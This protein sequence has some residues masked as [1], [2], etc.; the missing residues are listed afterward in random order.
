M[1]IMI[2][3][4]HSVSIKW[5]KLV[6]PLSI[7]A[8]PL[9]RVWPSVLLAS[10]ACLLPGYIYTHTHTHTGIATSGSWWL[11]THECSVIRTEWKGIQ[12]I[13]MHFE[14]V[15]TAHTPA[16]ERIAHR[17]FSLASRKG[18]PRKKRETV[19]FVF[20]SRI[21]YW[22]RRRQHLLLFN[23]RMVLP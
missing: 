19:G 7:H 6:G 12:S 4:I 14:S 18:E 5:M 20:I 21:K 15:V 16:D 1:I 13:R 3:E 10:F 11:M 22:W 17:P 8:K 23:F 2:R 9:W